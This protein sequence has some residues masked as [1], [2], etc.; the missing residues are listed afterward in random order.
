MAYTDGSKLVI[1]IW[2]NNKKQNVLVQYINRHF[3]NK[4]VINDS[5]IITL[6]TNADVGDRVIIKST[7]ERIEARERH[8]KD[9]HTITNI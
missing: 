4:I 8:I 2:H 9:G 3:Y 7:L 6:V 5:N 1:Y